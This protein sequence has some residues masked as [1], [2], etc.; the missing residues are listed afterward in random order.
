MLYEHVEDSWERLSDTT[1]R[2][3]VFV[4]IDNVSAVHLGQGLNLPGNSV[5]V[6]ARMT[7]HVWV[8]EFL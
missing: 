7:L 3:L 5:A 4:S 6:T 8:R 2:R 1:N